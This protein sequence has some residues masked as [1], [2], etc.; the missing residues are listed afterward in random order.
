MYANDKRSRTSMAEEPTRFEELARWRGQVDTRLGNIEEGQAISRALM[1]EMRGYFDASLQRL[2]EDMCR[3]LLR[4]QELSH[5]HTMQLEQRAGSM[6]IF[7]MLLPLVYTLFGAIVGGLVS[8]W[9]RK[10]MP[11]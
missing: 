2:H 8:L 7:H 6:Q 4:L 10:G 1:G 5:Q 9:L 3:N 11:T